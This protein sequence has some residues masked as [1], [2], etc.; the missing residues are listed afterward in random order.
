MIF[1]VMFSDS[2]SSFLRRG[3]KLSEVPTPPIPSFLVSSSHR[4]GGSS[5]IHCRTS[6]LLIVRGDGKCSLLEYAAILKN[7]CVT[8]V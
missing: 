7:I 1:E 6:L 2:L 3:K 4:G 5:I 8:W